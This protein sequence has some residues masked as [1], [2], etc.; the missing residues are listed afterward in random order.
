MA[1]ESS[2]SEATR[3]LLNNSQVIDLTTTGRR[4]GQLRRIEIFLVHMSAQPLARR[5]AAGTVQSRGSRYGP[6]EFFE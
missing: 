1:P 6:R 4:T 2:L 5:R 3:A